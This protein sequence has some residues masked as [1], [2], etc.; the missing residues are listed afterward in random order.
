MNPLLRLKQLSAQV[1]V[2]PGAIYLARKLRGYSGWLLGYGAGYVVE[3]SGE[4]AVLELLRNATRPVIVDAGTNLGEYTAAALDRLAGVNP[5][6]HCFE[7]FSELA[8]R[9][10]TRFGSRVHVAQCAL[11]DQTGEV[12]MHFEDGAH[13]LNSLVP[14]SHHGRLGAMLGQKITVKRTTLPRYCNEQAIAHINLLKLDV[15]GHELAVLRGAKELLADR[16]IDYL[17]FEF[18]ESNLDSREFLGDYRR[19]LETHGYTLFRILPAGR[20]LPTPQPDQRDECF[21]VA[22]YLAVSP[23]APPI[24]RRLVAGR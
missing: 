18:G 10:R 7:P 22:N 19:A 2:L 16:A 11:S 3:T 15:E 8:A 5:V 14:V 6:V 24:P 12:E 1:V 4:L 20:F 9:L 23:K 13:G 17:T 21:L